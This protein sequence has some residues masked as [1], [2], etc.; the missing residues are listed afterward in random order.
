MAKYRVTLNR[1][2]CIGAGS[3]VQAF[4][5]RFKMNDDGK[6][7]IVGG[8]KLPDK[9]QE[10]EI[11]EHEIDQMMEAAQSCPVNAIHI[12]DKNGEKLI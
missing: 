7:D 4:E 1:G 6:V 9:K 2:T 10:I 5:K 3:C 12:Q 8:Q 11:D